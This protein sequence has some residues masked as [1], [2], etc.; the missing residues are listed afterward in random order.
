MHIRVS[1]QVLERARDGQDVNEGR[2]GVFRQDVAA[3]CPHDTIADDVGGG[4]GGRGRQNTK[5]MTTSGFQDYT[6]R[7][8]ILCICRERERERERE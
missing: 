6:F 2:D 3:I 8:G 4:V 5:T 1:C 7:Q